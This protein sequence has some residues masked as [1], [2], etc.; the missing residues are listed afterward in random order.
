MKR[1]SGSTALLLISIAFATQARAANP[2]HVKQLLQTKQ[3]KGCDLSNARLKGA[4]LK[5]ANLEG[6][7]LEG[8]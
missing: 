8:V 1:L 4:S 5:G 3:C 6:A 7:N 2:E